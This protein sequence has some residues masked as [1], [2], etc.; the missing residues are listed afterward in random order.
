MLNTILIAGVSMTAIGIV[1]GGMLS[2]ASKKFAIETDER[3]DLIGEVLPGANCGSCGYAGCS[4]LAEA[5]AK[6]EAPYNACPVGG[7]PVAQKVADIMGVEMDA[8]TVRKTARVL[9][10]GDIKKCKINFDYQGVGDCNSVNALAG[11]SK[12]CQYGCL[13]Y[14]NCVKAC[15]F[16][17]I[18]INVNHIAEVD[19]DNCVA[20]GKCVEACPK[21]IIQLV[22]Y[23]NRTYVK[24]SNKDT[25]KET[26]VKCTAGCIG[27]RMCEKNCP[28]EAIKVVDNFAHVDYDKCI[29]CG[30]CAEKCPVKCIQTKEN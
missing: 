16:D 27:C 22:P 11:G 29:N 3:I 18:H 13:G 6:G 30:I 25:G 15:Q 2:V 14:G 23:E 24:C 21:H 26:R 5:I 19:E 4:G 28:Q 1:F 17:A 10:G 8:D 7:A 20:C 12:A 9:C